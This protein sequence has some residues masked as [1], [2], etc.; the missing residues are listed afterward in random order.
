MVGKQMTKHESKLL[1]RW[2]EHQRRGKSIFVLLRGVLP[3]VVGVFVGVLGYAALSPQ[4]SV[5]WGGALFLAL[6]VAATGGTRASLTWKR[7]E[8][9]YA[10][11]PQRA[12]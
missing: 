1:A 11:S 12:S 8:G 9:I 10:A 4:H 7:I 5:H 3:G 2:P 6:V